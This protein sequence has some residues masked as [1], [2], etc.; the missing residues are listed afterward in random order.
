MSSYNWLGI[1]IEMLYVN[2][3]NKNI[4]RLSLSFKIAEENAEEIGE[5]E[6]KCIISNSFKSVTKWYLIVT[7]SSLLWV[8]EWELIEELTYYNAFN[9]RDESIIIF[10][11]FCGTNMLNVDSFKY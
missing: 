8:N 7:S 10:F 11:F 4:E 3:T 6:L 5:R 1:N 9:F 2:N